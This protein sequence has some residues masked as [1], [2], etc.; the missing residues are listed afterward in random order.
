MAYITKNTTR[1]PA[2]GSDETIQVQMSLSGSATAFTLCSACE[3][4][5]WEREG[6]RVELP[7]VLGLVARRR[8]AA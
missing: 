5:G 7:A 2:C 3:W 8:A 1:C 6:A 4:K